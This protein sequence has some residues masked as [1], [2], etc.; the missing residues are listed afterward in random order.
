MG[1]KQIM[2]T[3]CL[4]NYKLHSQL[5]R[6]THHSPGVSLSPTTVPVGCCV[7]WNS[8]LGPVSGRVCFLRILKSMSL[9]LSPSPGIHLVRHSRL[10]QRC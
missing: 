5:K 3:V 7:L 6:D 8:S 2:M 4:H 1:H 9:S 10:P